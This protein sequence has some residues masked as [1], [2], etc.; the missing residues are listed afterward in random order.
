MGRLNRSGRNNRKTHPV[1]LTC[2]SVWLSDWLKLVLLRKKE[3]KIHLWQ[4]GRLF[5]NSVAIDTVL[6]NLVMVLNISVLK[7]CKCIQSGASFR[8]KVQWK[9]MDT[10]IFTA[11]T[12]NLGGENGGDI[13]N[14]PEPPGKQPDHSEM[15][16]D[17]SGTCKKTNKLNDTK[18][19]HSKNGWRRGGREHSKME[20]SEKGVKI[21]GEGERKTDRTQL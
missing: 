1:C 21:G 11:T 2:L 7:L 18:K 10:P 20:V 9:N 14:A 6:I 5:Q 12:T 17:C 19:H 4:Q 13:I 15:S 8:L 3:S 16:C